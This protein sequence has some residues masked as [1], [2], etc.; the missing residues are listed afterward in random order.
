MA[1][2]TSTKISPLANELEVG[3]K[4]TFSVILTSNKP[5]DNNKYIIVENGYVQN[6][7]FDKQKV[8]LV[9]KNESRDFTATAEFSFTVLAKIGGLGANVNNNDS[10]SFT[11]NTDAKSDATVFPNMPHTYNSKIKVKPVSSNKIDITINK[12]ADLIIGQKVSFFCRI[13]LR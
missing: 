5:I 10:V 8:P 11:I 2:I 9:Y 1:A 3:Q 7:K 13:K 12:N 6:I 4:V